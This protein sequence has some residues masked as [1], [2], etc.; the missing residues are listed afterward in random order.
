MTIFRIISRPA[1]MLVVL[2]LLGGC[3]DMD[4]TGMGQERAR[5]ECQVHR[6]NTEYRDCIAR[7]NKDYDE[8]R[9]Q[10]SEKKRQE[11]K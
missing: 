11:S 3:A 2:G 7:V 8:L 9:S 4:L 10:R 6:D 1:S 5:S